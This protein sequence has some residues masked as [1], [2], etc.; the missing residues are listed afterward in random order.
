MGKCV[1]TSIIDCTIRLGNL[2]GIKVNLKNTQNE[3]GSRSDQLELYTKEELEE[4]R[5]DPKAFEEAFDDWLTGID[6]ATARAV[7]DELKAFGDGLI[8][9]QRR[10]DLED[11]ND[12]E[13]SGRNTT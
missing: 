3:G 7:A 2:G 4:C 8:A 10:T 13:N 1:E 6:A 11:N 5:I 9:E 12:Q